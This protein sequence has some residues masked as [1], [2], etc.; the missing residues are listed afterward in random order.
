MVN[1]PVG[2]KHW[3][4]AAQ[5]SWFFNLSIE[6]PAEDGS[7]QWLEPVDDSVYQNAEQ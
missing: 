1:I 5:D 6:A 4:G 3:H 2:V 7:T